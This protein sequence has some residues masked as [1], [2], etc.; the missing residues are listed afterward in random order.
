MAT[1]P[2]LITIDSQ[3][4]AKVDFSNEFL[5]SF[6]NFLF[7]CFGR[8]MHPGNRIRPASPVYVRKSL[9]IS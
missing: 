3:L 2:S 1:R 8:I 5:D 7:V 6:K 9:V 4:E